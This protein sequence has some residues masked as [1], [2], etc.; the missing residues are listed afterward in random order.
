M[1]RLRC[2]QVFLFLL[3]L[4]LPAVA[5]GWQGWRLVNQ[6]RDLNRSRSEKQSQEIRKRIAAE[7]GHDLY[8]RL[9]RIKFQEM[10][11]SPAAIPQP[12]KYSDPEAVVL[13]GKVDGEKL[14][15]PWEE[16]SPNISAHDA[17]DPDFDQK[18]RDAG[19]IES[20]EKNYERAAALYRTL[21]DTA[22]NDA[23]RAEAPRPRAR[24]ATK[25]IAGRSHRDSA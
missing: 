11:N 23:Q 12:G 5:L 10:A 15:W 4:V 2:R 13:I 8:D 14:V 17:E 19:R 16:D 3:V 1:S 9:E 24:A 18:M 6:E 22:R 21:A 20:G 7:I 25:R